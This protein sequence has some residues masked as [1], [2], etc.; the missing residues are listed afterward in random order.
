[1]V[2][3]CLSSMHHFVPTQPLPAPPLLPSHFPQIIS[4]R[5]ISNM[6]SFRLPLSRLRV[7]FDDVHAGVGGPDGPTVAGHGPSERSE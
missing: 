3:K 1:M 2:V 7:S 5:V 4:C 6:A